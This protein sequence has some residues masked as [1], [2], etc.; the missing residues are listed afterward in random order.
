MSEP[1]DAIEGLAKGENRALPKSFYGLN[2]AQF[3]GALN[4]NLYKLLVIYLFIDLEG[5]ENSYEILSLAGSIFV[6]PFLLFAAISGQA[7]DKL[8]KSRLIVGTKVFEVFISL[9]GILSIY[10]QSKVFCFISLFLYAFQSTIFGPSKYGILPEIVPKNL[11]SKANGVLT[12]FTYLAIIAGTFLASFILDVTDRSY[13]SGGAF[14]LIFS[15]IGLIGSLFIKT[16]L[17]VDPQKRLK[18]V[19]IGEIIKTLF[20]IKVFPPLLTIIFASSFFLLIAAF[21][22]LNL[23]PFAVTELKL[24]D[25]EG[26]YL[27]LLCAI[28]IA[29]GSY[30]IGWLSGKNILLAAVPVACFMLAI[31]FFLLDFFSNNLML[32]ALFIFGLGSIG[33]IYQIPL[34]AYIQLKSPNNQRGAVIAANSFLSFVGVLIA[35]FLVYAIKEII[36]VGPDRGF[37][38]IGILTL[39]F[40]A[41]LANVIGKKVEREAHQE[42]N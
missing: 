7:A 42:G 39:I 17:P 27:F 14:C 6:I 37:T 3:F 33:G 2:I 1:K 30:T 25:T 13:L 34:D 21:V 19:F 24:T 28:G 10:L 18:P 11:L 26:G 12:A 32:S 15:L 16:T 35:S 8:S 40:S 5:I 38:L 4:D 36:N 31:L 23:I 29:I 22:Q 20:D 41:Y 9:L